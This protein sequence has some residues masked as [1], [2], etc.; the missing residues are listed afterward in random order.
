MLFFDE[1]QEFPEIATALKFFE[2]DGRFDVICIE[3]LSETG[4][5]NVCYCMRYP[6]LPLKGVKIP[7]WRKISL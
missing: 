1:L 2:Q 7:R 5:V 3:W 4:I 6:E